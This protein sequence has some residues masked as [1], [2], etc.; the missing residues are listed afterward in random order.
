M[1][2]TQQ[3]QRS[4][5]A[6]M[7][8]VPYGEGTAFRVWA[9]HATDVRVAGSFNEFRDDEYPLAADGDGFWST[10][11]V[12]ARPGD[13]Y[14]FLVINGEQRMWRIDPY[15]REVTNSVGEGVIHD[16]RFDWGRDD[17]Y[18]TPPW[19]EMVIY[20]MHIGTFNLDPEKGRG[21]FDSA[22]TRLAYLADLGVNVVEIMPPAEFGGDIS[23]GY[24]PA[25]LFAVESGYGGPDA[26]RRFVRAAHEHHIAIVL[27]VVYNHF[28][29]S[30]LDLWQ[31][32]GWQE[33]GKG[34]IY[35]YNDWRSVTPWG[36]TRPDYGRHEVRQFL[37]DNALMWLDEY[38]IDGL[39]WDATA[40]IRNVEGE[41]DPSKDLPEGWAMMQWINNEIDARSPWKITIAEDLRNNP[42]MIGDT[43]SGGAGFDAQWDGGFV[44]PVRQA[45]IA[46]DDASRDM[47]AVANAILARAGASA[48]E[49]VIYTESHDD[50]ANGRARVP[51]EIAA[52]EADNWY[53][54]KRST[55]GAVVTAIAPG[56][57]MIF[58]GQEFLEDA[59]FNDQHMLDWQRAESFAGITAMYRDLF[60]LR[61]NFADTTRGLRGQHVH[62]SQI[63][64]VTGVLVVH[65]WQQ[66][67]AR[68]D[69]V[70]VLNLSERTYDDYRIGLPRSGEWCVRFNSDSTVYDSF[71]NDRGSADVLATGDDHDGMPDSALVSIGAYSALILSQD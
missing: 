4:A 64:E 18:R 15:A 42:A 12:A 33:H 55:L 1:T 71:F 21:T 59:W 69:V 3:P 7:G 39:R 6:G 26:L 56:I 44:H 63:N 41:G 45:I 54:K 52:G 48:F 8:A 25:H 2:T 14:K 9:P 37:R 10:D 57:P 49:R 51:E 22:I 24:N 47:Q 67:G 68:D 13:R 60:R 62:V 20:E 30:D 70:I 31:F 28:G 19:N 16:P 40:F 17:D 43:V 50:V 65:R 46:H 38:R 23:W 66:G 11:V 35:F 29:P 34:G 5:H 32:D 53:A 27:D 61:R 36:D 58:Q